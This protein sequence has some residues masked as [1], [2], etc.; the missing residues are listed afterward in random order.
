MFSDELNAHLALPPAKPDCIALPSLTTQWQSVRSAQ[1]CPC[2]WDISQCL[3]H[4][5]P[6]EPTAKPEQFG[7]TGEVHE[8]WQIPPKF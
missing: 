8:P 3:L 1:C 5:L 7:L 4:V 6:L 2:E